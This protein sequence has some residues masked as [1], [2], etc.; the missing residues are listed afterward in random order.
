MD[1]LNCRRS[2]SLTSL[3][4][5]KEHAEDAG[6]RCS[7]TEEGNKRGPL[8]T[9]ALVVVAKMANSNAVLEVS[10]LKLDLIAVYAWV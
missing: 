3:E 7:L 5:F 4:D 8:A 1:S 2:K 10:I 9:K 6:C